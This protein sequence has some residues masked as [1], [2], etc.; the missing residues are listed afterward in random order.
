MSNNYHFF[1]C[2][3]TGHEL[4]NF[5]ME[6]S[7]LHPKHNFY[8]WGVP[9]SGIG[10]AT[11]ILDQV[12]IKYPESNNYFIFQVSNKGRVG[13]WEKSCVKYIEPKR[14]HELTNYFTLE[15]TRGEDWEGFSP[16][17]NAHTKFAKIYYKNI[18][19]N[20]LYHELRIY[21]N[22]AK[23][24]SN[25]LFYHNPPD[26]SCDE[27]VIFDVLGEKT[28]DE[29]RYEGDGQHFSKRGCI[30]QANWIWNKLEDIQ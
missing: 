30:W 10:L 29:Y 22:Y 19:N 21:A 5:V 13:W 11:F 18:E 16:G 12:K 4:M 20:V 3:W 27:P 2:S 1:G 15:L 14:H 23:Q 6:L 28:F 17:F 9:G 7:K 26:Y 25:F 8:N 24:N